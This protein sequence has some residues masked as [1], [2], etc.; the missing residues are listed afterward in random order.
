MNRLSSEVDVDDMIVRIEEDEVDDVD[1]TVERYIEL[2]LMLKAVIKKYRD[3]N[4]KPK[5]RARDLFFMGSDDLTDIFISKS[6]KT[7][8]DLAY[9]ARGHAIFLEGKILDDSSNDSIEE[10]DDYSIELP[11]LD[12]SND[13]LDPDTWDDSPLSVEDE[14]MSRYYDFIDEVKKITR[15]R[16][17]YNLNL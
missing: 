6:S 16:E 17:Y 9:N 15:G 4:L 14:I 12:F 3:N 13:V 8:T 11:T 5:I 10:T 7:L 2:R 1:L